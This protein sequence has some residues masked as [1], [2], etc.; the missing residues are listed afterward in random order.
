M[1]SK[2]DIRLARA[3]RKIAREFHREAFG[4]EAARLHR[5]PYAQRLRHMQKLR[6]ARY[7]KSG[8]SEADNL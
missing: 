4:E 7:A 6:A 1:N 3:V 8:S 2:V 5:L